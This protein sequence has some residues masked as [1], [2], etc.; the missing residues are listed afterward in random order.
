MFTDVLVVSC[1]PSLPPSFTDASSS[2][3]SSDEEVREAFENHTPPVWSSISVGSTLWSP[4]Q[5]PIRV[6]PSSCRKRVTKYFAQMASTEPIERPRLDFNKMQSRRLAMVSGQL[7]SRAMGSHVTIC[8]LSNCLCAASQLL[9]TS[10]FSGKP[11][12]PPLA[13]CL[14]V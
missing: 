1:G 5:R 14:T 8:S 7:L 3:S 10:A 4:A 12:P 6:A 13:L 11:L 2:A 9:Q